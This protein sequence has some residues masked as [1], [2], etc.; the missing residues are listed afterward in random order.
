MPTEKQIVA[1][2]DMLTEGATAPTAVESVAA[3][4]ETLH[5]AAKPWTEGKGIQG[6][7]VGEKITDGEQLQQVV[8]KV[9]VDRKLPKSQLD[10]PVP[11]KVRM[12]GLDEQVETDV[13]EIGRMEKEPNTAK[14]RPAIPGFGL[15]HVKITVG[16]FGCLV[17]KKGEKKSLYILSN[18]HVLADEGTGQI[19]DHIIQPG[20][21]DG[22]KAADVIAELAAWA[23]FQFTTTGYPNFVDAAIAKVK[24]AADVTSAVRLIGVPKGT[25]K[26]VRR[27]M[28][29]Q[30]TGRT[31]DYTIGVIKDINYRLALR[32]KK[33]GGGMGRVGLADQV[34]CTRYTAGGDSGSAV[35]NMSGKVV[36]LHFA[37]SPSTSVF[38]RIE[39]VLTALDIELVTTNV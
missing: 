38:N 9:Y 11:P 17:R 37:G 5:K 6:I 13:E 34:L 14:M 2:L 32:Y 35:F 24:K 16:T 25:S 33:P 18:S 28:Q 15:G 29:V 19:G 30:K 39:H 7:G 8:L 1:L 26:F 4:A 21:H 12:P 3:A 20:D 31:T 27:G 22:G 10:N 36:G 23:P